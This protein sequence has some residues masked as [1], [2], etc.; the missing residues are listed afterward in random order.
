MKMFVINETRDDAFGLVTFPVK[1][2]EDDVKILPCMDK[3]IEET[4]TMMS[5][6]EFKLVYTHAWYNLRHASTAPHMGACYR[7]MVALLFVDNENE[8]VF[9]QFDGEE[10][11]V[12]E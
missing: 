7:L 1:V 4:I 2:V 5:D 11:D 10:V 12:F 6:R 8:R 9:I 3:L